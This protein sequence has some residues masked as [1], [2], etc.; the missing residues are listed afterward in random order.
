VLPL[1]IVFDT[2]VYI[3]SVM[4]PGSFLDLEIRRLV[5]AG[6]VKLYT[7]HA[8]LLE[9]REKAENKFRLSPVDSRDLLTTRESLCRVVG[10]TRRVHVIVRNSDDNK[11]LECALEAGADVIISA[12]KDLLKL[13]V[14]EGIKII[15]PSSVKYL[16][17]KLPD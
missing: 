4:H 10:P 11:I 6:L 7:S 3:Q 2:N 9:L 16:F 1:K 17:P 14:F 15:H 13:K 12:D 5:G 8:I